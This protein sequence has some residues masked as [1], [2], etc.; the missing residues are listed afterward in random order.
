V[1]HQGKSF[2]IVVGHGGA[3]RGRSIQRELARIAGDGVQFFGRP[4]AVDPGRDPRAELASRIRRQLDPSAPQRQRG[5]PRDSVGPR[6][7]QEPQLAIGLFHA[8]GVAAVA[9][10]DLDSL[11]VERMNGQSDRRDRPAPEHVRP[12]ARRRARLGFGSALGLSVSGLPRMSGPCPGAR[13]EAPALCL[14]PLLRLLLIFDYVMDTRLTSTAGPM[15]GCRTT[16]V[17][18]NHGPDGTTAV[19]GHPID[20][21]VPVRHWPSHA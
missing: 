15:R 14:D 10:D 16:R 8:H 5:R 13:R 20:E 6:D 19:G 1:L 17:A 11:A 12:R 7:R 2:P 4:A 3:V 21:G 18:G 9:T